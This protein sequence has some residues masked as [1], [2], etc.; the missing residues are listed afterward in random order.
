MSDPIDPRV[1]AGERM[2]AGHHP[3]WRDDGSCSYCGSISV[4][5]AMRRLRTPGCKFSGTD[6]TTYKAYIETPDGREAGAGKFYFRHLR[7]CAEAELAEF[8]ELARPIFGLSFT[9]KDGDILCRYPRTSGFY[10]WQTSGRIGDDGAP[11]FDEGS[12]KAPG[13]EFWE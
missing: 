11:V 9:L 2:Y 3:A 7:A 1:H 8:D 6:K 13:P 4:P 5:E 12:P 10:G